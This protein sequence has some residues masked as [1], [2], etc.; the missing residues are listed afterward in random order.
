MI[1]SFELAVIGA[2]PGGMEATISATGNGV[3]TVLIDNYPNPGGQYFMQIP[4]NFKVDYENKT[5]TAGRK[6]VNEALKTNAL[7]VLNC[8]VW[9]LF[10][11][12]DG[13]WLVALYGPNAPKYIK[14][15]HL[16]LATGSYD[17]P[18]AFPGWTLPGVVTSGG[19]LVLLKNQRVAPGKR[20]VVSGTG[21][22][23]F[24]VAAH[25]IEAG[26]EV[27]AVCEANH[28]L[29]RGIKYA[30]TMLKQWNRLTEGAKYMKT[31]LG[32][33]TPYK[34]GWSII[35]ARGNDSV[36]QA[37]IA[38][39]DKNG[40]PIPGSEK[41]LD[42]DLVVSGFTLTPN[43]GLPRMIDCDM[44]YQAGKGGWIPL[45]DADFQTSIP[46][47][48]V[49]GDGA[50]VGGAENARLEGRFA[51]L[52]VARNSGHLSSVREKQSRLEMESDLRQQQRFGGLLSDLFAPPSGLV[53]ILKDDTIICRC[54]EITLA[55]IKSAI[56]MG[57][58]SI[59]EVKMLTRTGMGNCQGRMCEHTVAAIIAHELSGKGITREDVGYYSIRPPLHPLPQSFLADAVPEEE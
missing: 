1:E 56:Q 40:K 11:E 38:K 30:S 41:V 48:Y 27:V 42:V 43:T 37:V 50:G 3:K 18:V 57:A 8:L 54:E 2:G 58:R 47:V 19:T 10:Q 17:T 28:I 49:V 36:Q 32:A 21:P 52:A 24:S 15:K 55:E 16:I 6:M 20:V 7:K 26:V 5:E 23:L 22:L 33:K 9:G 4:T 53:S 35:E 12:E 46:N 44:T 59:G 51:G 29:P 25:L 31:I 34:I 45:R 39:V 14:A 13:K